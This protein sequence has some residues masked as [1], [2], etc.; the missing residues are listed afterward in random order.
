MSRISPEDIQGLLNCI[1][2]SPGALLSKI[3]EETNSAVTTR[4]IQR[5]LARLVTEGRIRREGKG[6]ATRYYPPKTEFPPLEE[7]KLSPEALESH[8]LVSRPLTA[9][10]PVGYD[11][12]FLGSYE[13]NK[14]EYLPKSLCQELAKVGH[15]ANHEQPAGT[16]L[17]QILDRLLIDLSYHSSRLEGNTYSLLETQK[18]LQAGEHFSEKAAEETQMLLNHKRAIELLA[19]QPEEIGFNRYTILN[20]HAL[21][22]DNLLSDNSACGRLRDRPVG[23][24]GSVFHPLEIPQAHRKP[25]R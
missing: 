11:V 13:P 9:R 2:R 7:I 1:Q 20:L 4:T 24:G 18:L 17:R 10:Q 15:I 21:L 5:H 19:D 22:S 3:V 8:G 23:I 14:T 25:I 12:E 6:K 16:Y